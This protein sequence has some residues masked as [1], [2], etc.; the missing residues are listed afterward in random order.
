MEKS[1]QSISEIKHGVLYADILCNDGLFKI[2]TTHFTWTPQGEAPSEE[3]VLSMKAFLEKMQNMEPHIICGDFNIPRT[4]NVLYGELTK[5]YTDAVPATYA[6][7]LDPSLHTLGNT[8]EKRHLFESF[9]VDYVFTQ[10]PY[11]ASDVR[12]EFG[13]SD[14]AAV[15]ATITA[16]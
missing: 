5:H 10:P 1:L 15:V 6:S 12:L 3:Q 8:P 11:T 4:E 9:M 13:L 14:H 16:S 2:A 7:S